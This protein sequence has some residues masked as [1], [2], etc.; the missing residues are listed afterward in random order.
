M[1]P[2]TPLFARI[3][4]KTSL[5][6]A[7]PQHQPRRIVAVVHVGIGQRDGAVVCQFDLEATVLRAEM[8]EGRDR[9]AL[10]SGHAAS[11]VVAGM[12]SMRLQRP[13]GKRCEGRQFGGTGALRARKPAGGIYS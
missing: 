11:P 6:V 12:P 10:D 4:L 8:R 1:E 13:R 7:M 9:L 5:T 2:L 3:V